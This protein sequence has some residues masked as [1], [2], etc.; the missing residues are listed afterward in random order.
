M[1]N[2]D[3]SGATDKFTRSIYVQYA[4]SDTLLVKKTVCALPVAMWLTLLIVPPLSAEEAGTS[5]PLSHPSLGSM[6]LF[7]DQTRHLLTQFHSLFGVFAHLSASLP[8]C[9]IHLA[10]FEHSLSLLNKYLCK[11]LSH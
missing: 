4:K 10:H 8:E 5:D 11:P 2:Y 1:L 7:H 6:S 9:S 3:W